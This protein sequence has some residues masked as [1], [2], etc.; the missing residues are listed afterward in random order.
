MASIVLSTAGAAVG[1]ALPGVGPVVGSVLGRVVGGAIGGLIDDA[2]FGVPTSYREGPRLADLTVQVSTYGKAIPAVYGS[3]RLAGNILWS[4]PIKETATTTTSSSGGGKGGGGGGSRTQTTTYSYSVSLAIGIC[5]GPI[6]RVLRVWADAKLLNLSQ[7][8]Y[9]IYKG[10][11]SQLPDSFIQSIEGVGR[12][13]AYRGL[14]YVVIEDFPLADFGNRIPNFTFEVKRKLVMEDVGGAPVEELVKSVVMIPGA[15]EFVYDTSIQ[16]KISGEAVGSGWAQS[17]LAGPI[18]RHT[19]EGKAN[20]LVSL[21]DLKETCPNVEW[22]GVVVCW[23]GT[24]LD[25]ATCEVLPAVEYKVGGQTQ[26]E[27]WSVGG[28]TRATARQ[29]TLEDG[30]P[31]Y[32]GTPDDQS[33][34]RYLDA[35]K[36]RGYKVLLLPM[37]FMDVPGK[38]WR[39]RLTGTASAV[40]SFFT[41]TNGYN[42]FITHYANLCAG[43]VDAFA[44]G[45]EMVGLT[46]VMSTPGTFP[47]VNQ[48]VSLA[49][50]V[51]GILGS[52]VKLT[53]AADWSEY[54]HTESGWY[55]LDPLWA[56]S[57]I[58]FIGIDAYFPLTDEPQSGITLAKA[59]AG[60][61][62]GEGY[63]WYYTDASRTTKAS[64]S[65]AYAWKNLSWF[66]A[67][68]HVNPD[69]NPTAWVPNS[70]KIWFTE[71]GFPSVDGATNQ[72]NVFFD[73][74]SSESFFPRFSRGLVDMRAQ[75][76]GIAATEAVWGASSLVE[77]RFLWTWDAR[78][79]PYFP[80]LRDVW[81]DGGVW[82]T[83]HWVTGKLGLSSLGAIVR[84]LCLKAG[85]PLERIDVSRLTQ[86][87]EGYVVTRQASARQLIEE[88]MAAYF[89]D[90]VESGGVLRFIPRGEGTAVTLVE[91]ALVSDGAGASLFTLTRQ[92]ELE[93]PKSVSVLHLSRTAQ[94]QTG[95]QT[96][97]RH[98]ASGR[99]AETFSLPL[100][101][102]DAEAKAVAEA[103][104][105]LRWLGRQRV[106]F[107]LDNRYAALEPTDVVTLEQNGT[108]HMLRIT[109]TLRDQGKV[110]V[111]AVADDVSLYQPY[112]PPR[113]A[114][115]LSAAVPP[116]P[117]TR[118]ELLD[119]PAF[120]GDTADAATL[121]YAATGLSAGW[122]GAVLYRSDDGGANYG[123]IATL[124]SA[125]VVGTAVTVLAGSAAGNRFD[126]LGSVTVRL[127][128]EEGL[129][130]VTA[131]AVLNGANAA[132]LGDEILQ[133]REAEEVAE[134]KY[135][136][137]GLLRGR[138]GTEAA[139]AS[140]TLG[141][142]FVLLDGR[143]GRELLSPSL[144]NL[145][146]EYKPVTIGG[147]LGGAAAQSF[148]YGGRALRPLAPVHLRGERDAGGNLTARWVRRARVDYGWRDFV[149]VPL[150]EASEQYRVEVLN[151]ATV[152]RTFTTTTPSCTYTAAQQTADFGTPQPSVTL[153]ICQFSSRV[154]PGERAQ[155]VL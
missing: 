35:L 78:P 125:A 115:G 3:A 151:D 49:A 96:A 91:D 108:T 134:G 54:H 103:H 123:R 145:P 90:A 64:L 149:D 27:Q 42:A 121:R 92:Q 138:L 86:R 85:L 45:S 5:E 98:S 28:F 7:G 41:K 124:E 111:E 24:S 148:T 9:R 56:S 2:V 6:D 104:L 50:T 8:T 14:A 81:A 135:V 80:D 48:F 44:I 114:T 69:G 58:D 150:D 62:S 57:N 152:V 59:M 46:K 140:H 12:T 126:E 118:L 132:L 66:C 32:G 61:T 10:D 97:Y 53:Y 129:Q 110:R 89:F 112:A 139:M 116:L 99:D 77:R 17:G 47:A 100:V 43:R 136:L 102:A 73:P 26:P 18:N 117:A 74:G 153:R 84:L 23:F 22:V 107:L 105:Y 25:A 101:M 30:R 83:G 33:L 75:R 40:S 141:E 36:A 130:S 11:E 94:Y 1:R 68:P 133:F 15:G 51:R 106:Q 144:L 39:G 109:R 137:R 119:L 34:L 52:G 82:L 131:L 65:P 16:Q 95:T 37:C 155:G 21:D 55:N 143:V 29:M 88:L 31:R 4:R 20:A 93:L 38:P 146:R 19:P 127:I 13:P 79:Y 70:K 87:V 154:G 120:P 72:P 113:D 76:L 122:R 147:T 142:R 60:W 63:D 67:N 128:G 71:Y